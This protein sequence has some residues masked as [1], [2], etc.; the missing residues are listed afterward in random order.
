[1]L[2]E[3]VIALL[4]FYGDFCYYLTFYLFLWPIFQTNF[5]IKFFVRIFKARRWILIVMETLVGS[6]YTKTGDKWLGTGPRK[7]LLTHP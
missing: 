4:A 7:I 6:M 5:G 1:M 2:F 3:T